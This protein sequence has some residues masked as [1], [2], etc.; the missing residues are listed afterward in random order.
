MESIC[1]KCTSLRS[2]RKSLANYWGALAKIK[3]WRR[4]SMDFIRRNFQNWGYIHNL[5]Q[6]HHRDSFR[7][8]GIDFMSR[9]SVLRIKSNW[10]VVLV[11]SCGTDKLPFLCNFLRSIGIQ[12]RFTQQITW[13]HTAYVSIHSRTC[14]VFDELTKWMGPS[15][16]D[17]TTM[18]T[19]IWHIFSF[20][21]QHDL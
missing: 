9:F 6:K 21:W 16:M 8:D 11:F 17:V 20:C 14:I 5:F 19:L 1:L 12:E 13:K 4:H 15:Y 18:C 3:S 7:S 10:M 2:I